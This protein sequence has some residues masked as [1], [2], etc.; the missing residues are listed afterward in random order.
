[1]TFY[2]VFQIFLLVL[3]AIGMICF[4]RAFN[5]SAEEYQ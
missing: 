4:A 1:M 2:L 3:T 5:N